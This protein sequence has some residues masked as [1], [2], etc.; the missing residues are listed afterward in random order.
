M[1]K[2]LFLILFLII[3]IIKKSNQNVYNNDEIFKINLFKLSNN[4]S[5]KKLGNNIFV[6]DNFYNN[7]DNIR[8]YAL[9]N[10]SKYIVHSA[11]YKTDFFNPFLYSNV[12]ADL[13]KY[14]EKI[15][16]TK[17]DYSQW[18]KDVTKQSNGFIQLITKKSN[19]V[20]HR[21]VHW[22]VIV[23]LTPNPINPSGTSLYRHKQ[24]NVAHTEDCILLKNKNINKIECKY[25]VKNDL[26][27]EGEESKI[28]KWEINHRVENRYN[29][30]IIFDGRNFHASDGGFG[31]NVNDGR[32]FQTFFF[33]PFKHNHF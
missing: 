12:S 23:Y 15:S 14:F 25:M 24:T 28:D 16:N 19:P 9:D 8:K 32:L 30:A 6:I 31:N 22:G 13:I 1:N 29:R 4:Q 20:V 27:K 3:F 7:P 10:K 11:L 33:S 5:I 26:W 18:D 2:V 17:I 21:D